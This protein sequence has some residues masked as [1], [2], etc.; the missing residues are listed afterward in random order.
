MA[1]KMST[2]Y[3]LLVLV[4]LSACVDVAL[5]ARCVP[6]AMR[7]SA[8]AARAPPALLPR[9]S[10]TPAACCLLPL[11]RSRSG[12]P[13]DG[14]ISSSRELTKYKYKYKKQPGAPC[15]DDRVPQRT[16]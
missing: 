15:R 5:A 12:V 2:G 6:C 7:C 16:H 11:I 13:V 1:C 4:L 9:A 3:A 10:L 8:R 14:G